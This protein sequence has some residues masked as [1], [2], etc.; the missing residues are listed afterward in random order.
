MVENKG[1]GEATLAE[2]LD[3][4]FSTMH[5]RGRGEYTYEEVAE[6]IRQRGGSISASYIWMLRKGQQTNP[7][8]GHLEALADFFGV[9]VSYF[10]DQTVA[11]RVDAQLELLAAMREAGVQEIALRVSEL[12]PEGRRA[13]AAMIKQVRQLQQGPR[14]ADE[15][16]RRSEQQGDRSEGEDDNA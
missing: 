6:G 9:P 14:H 4:L 3:R 7:S 15:G 12:T 16:E 10:F 2:K 11:D 8:K 13:I 5:P 1:P